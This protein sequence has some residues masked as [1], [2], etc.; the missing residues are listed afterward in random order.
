MCAATLHVKRVLRCGTLAGAVGRRAAPPGRR[1]AARGA[2]GSPAP[3]GWNARAPLLS[4]ALFS[5]RALTAPCI[6]LGGTL[7]QL[8]SICSPSKREQQRSE[9]MARPRAAWIACLLGARSGWARAAA[10]WAA[11]VRLP[12]ACPPGPAAAAA[13]PPRRTE[14]HRREFSV[15]QSHRALAPS[16][17]FLQS[18]LP[19]PPAPPP[20]M[21]A[22]PLRPASCWCASSPPPAGAG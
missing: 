19:P 22:P 17:I 3:P 5:R 13:A 1:H 18:P 21:A 12:M 10:V 15:L 7:L 20:S 9:G 4:A 2:L 6:R 8:P 11:C 14:L 16:H